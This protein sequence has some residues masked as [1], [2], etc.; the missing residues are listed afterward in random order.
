M[1]SPSGA[2]ASPYSS[3]SVRP[4]IGQATAV[5]MPAFDQRADHDGGAADVVDV[6]GGIF[7]AR[8]Q[9]ADQRR[10]RKDLADIVDA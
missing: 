5:D 8:P 3:A 6:L 4:V 1:T 2:L 10:A 7:A 9:I